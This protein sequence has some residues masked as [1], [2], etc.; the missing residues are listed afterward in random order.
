MCRPRK[1]AARVRLFD[2]GHNRKTDAH[3]AHSIAVVA[4]RLEGLRV[5]KVDAELEALRMLTDRREA[6]T[7]RRIQTVA[8]LQALLAE[9]LPGQAKKDIPTGQAKAMLASVRPRDIAGKT[10][11][12]IAADELAELVAV[13]AKIQEGRR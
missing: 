4:V 9:L 1:L 7:R 13:E 5:L 12:R 6:L 10:R 11:R 2:T 3:D 8:R